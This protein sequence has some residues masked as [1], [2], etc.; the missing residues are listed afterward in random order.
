M[1]HIKPKLPFPY[2]IAHY[3]LNFTGRTGCQMLLCGLG[4]II[5]NRKKHLWSS[6]LR[7]KLVARSTCTE[8][9]GTSIDPNHDARSLVSQGMC[10]VGTERVHTTRLEGAFKHPHQPRQ[11]GTAGPPSRCRDLLIFK[12]GKQGEIR[13]LG[14]CISRANACPV[15]ES[16]K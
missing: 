6:H 9:G 1:K 14:T 10:D 16:C 5:P 3:N 7:H 13:L 11:G 15:P 4:L 2:S 8:C 12:V